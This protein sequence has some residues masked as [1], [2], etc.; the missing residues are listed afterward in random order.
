VSSAAARPAVSASKAAVP[1][2]KKLNIFNFIN[3]RRL[4]WRKTTRC[5]R[6]VNAGIAPGDGGANF[7][8]LGSPHNLYPNLHLNPPPAFED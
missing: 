2:V 3:L 1:T 8:F 6:P 7:T 5:S 4:D